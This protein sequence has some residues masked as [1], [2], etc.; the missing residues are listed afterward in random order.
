MKYKQHLIKKALLQRLEWEYSEP[1]PRERPSVSR[2]AASSRG[3]RL[4]SICSNSS[5]SFSS[6]FHSPPSI[7]LTRLNFSLS[8]LSSPFQSK[9]WKSG[10]LPIGVSTAL[11]L[12][13]HRS[14]IHFSTP[15]FS[16]HPAQIN[17]PLAS[18]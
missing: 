11:P 15:R 14:P 7:E 5:C 3:K 4:P 18:V 6:R 16:P 1:Q 13:S 17:F 9:S 10:T 8:K 12:P 2:R